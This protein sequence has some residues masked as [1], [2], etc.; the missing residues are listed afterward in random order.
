MLDVAAV[1]LFKNY[2]YTTALSIK[3]AVIHWSHAVVN[4]FTEN[5]TAEEPKY[6]QKSPLLLAQSAT[7]LKNS[8]DRTLE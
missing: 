6:Q 8:C 7:A 4:K 3:P 1:S 5:C 2:Y